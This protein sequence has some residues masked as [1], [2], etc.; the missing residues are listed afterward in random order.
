[1]RYLLD[2]DCCIAVLSGQRGVLDR[3]STLSP[4]DCAVSAVTAYELFAGAAKARLPERER[5]RLVRF[6]EMF[7]VLD[8]GNDATLRA[9]TV[10]VD[11][12]KAGTPIGPYD[13]LIAGH[14][15]TQDLTLATGN[16]REFKRI[17]TL[18]VEKWL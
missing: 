9:A 17:R 4:D 3:L 16:L 14:A 15:L 8:F 6:F 13:I 12:E 18:R 7:T 10:R 5:E 1:M 11:L 2:T